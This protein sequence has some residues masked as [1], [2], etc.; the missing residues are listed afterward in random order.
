MYQSPYRRRRGKLWIVLLFF[1]AVAIGL[2]VGYA[3][4]K[5]STL[6]NRIEAT[7]KESS[8]PENSPAPILPT[9]D[10]ESPEKAVSLSTT[11]PADT[12]RM[13]AKEGFLVK[14]TD[15]KVCVFNINADGTTTYSQTLP[16]SL[17]D[18]PESDR[19]KLEAGI[20]LETRTDL[21]ELMEDY[22][23]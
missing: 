22:S 17:G 13:P 12:P 4:A 14:T 21:A 6:P 19:K 18:L 1:C 20:Y 23:S 2:G 9:Y 3:G 15:G 5:I 7:P 10:P 11:I 8:L 16:V